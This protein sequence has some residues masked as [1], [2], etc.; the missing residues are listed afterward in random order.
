MARPVK[1]GLDY[2]PLDVVLGGGMEDINCEYGKLGEMV[3]I[4]LWQRIYRSSYYIE[5]NEKKLRLYAKEF[6]GQL[7]TLFGGDGS[8]GRG[9]F[10]AIVQLAAECGIFDRG[11]LEREGILTSKKIQEIYLEAKKKSKTV[12]IDEKFR[13]VEDADCARGAGL[14]FSGAF[15]EK[16]PQSKVKKN[17]S[18]VNKSKVNKSKAEESS[19]YADG[20]SEGNTAAEVDT[21]GSSAVAADNTDSENDT[22]DD[23]ETE[24]AADEG[25]S[26]G[27]AEMFLTDLRDSNAEYGDGESEY[28][29]DRGYSEGSDKTVSGVQWDNDTDIPCDSGTGTA[30][31][32][33]ADTR[34]NGTGG[35]ISETDCNDTA[36]GAAA[37]E[38][39]A[40]RNTAADSRKT[41]KSTDAAADSAKTWKSKDGAVN[42][43]KT[44]K[45]KDGAADSRKTLKSTDAA[46]DSA[47]TWKS[48]D[49]AANGAQTQ[50]ST[51][52]TANAQLESALRAYEK[53]VGMATDNVKRRVGEYLLR[54]MEARLIARLAEYSAEQGKRTWQ[55]LEAAILGN[56][57]DGIKTLD[58]YERNQSARAQRR[59]RERAAQRL[60][61]GAVMRGI[62]N[63]I[64]TNKPDYSNFKEE[65]LDGM[66]EW[67]MK[68]GQRGD[69][70]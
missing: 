8:C 13:L 26:E 59:K 39:A 15:S 2:F 42:G 24:Y 31:M 55:Y 65:V 4:S 11:L 18:K 63:Y 57:R 12:A 60:Q 43:A 70:I 27:S 10:D 32:N 44:W 58:A 52:T 20:K 56:F 34:S 37:E 64:D 69:L 5:Y 22:D 16:T 25:Y 14:E 46:A 54:G 53:N 23:G 1:K 62:N 61:G 66:D 21:V 7:E 50:K 38:T 47:K 41:L 40:G 28:A 3:V 29:A 35:D 51:G 45:S 19:K 68:N 30:G 36:E 17:K 67:Y 6:C 49:G 9:I 33:S 48:K